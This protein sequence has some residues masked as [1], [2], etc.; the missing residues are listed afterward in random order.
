MWPLVETCPKPLL[1]IGGKPIIQW[2]IEDLRSAGIRNIIISIGYLGEQISDALGRGHGLG[3]KIDYVHQEEERGVA[4]SILIA[5]E[6]FEDED[7]FLVANADIL[8][9]PKIIRRAIRHYKDLDAEAVVSLTLTNTPQFF[10][11]AVIDE[12]A[13]IRK[14]IEKPKPEE[15]QSRYAIAGIYVFRPSIFEHLRKAKDLPVTIQNLIEKDEKVYGSVWERE[16]VEVSYPWDLVQANQ[17]VL[18]K[19]LKGKGS[20]IAESAD[21][22]QP[23]RIEGSVHISD[24]V[25][26][27]PHTTIRGP[28]YIGPD[29]YIGNNSLIREY[30]SLGAN[31]LVGFGCEIKESII[32]DS[33]KIGRLSFVGDSVVGRNVEI[34][35]G[36]QLVNYPL[37]GTTITSVIS[38]KPEIVP[39]KKYGAVIGDHSILS[40]NVS[41]FPGVKVGTHSI[42]LPGTVLAEDVPSRT[43]AR[44]HQEVAF[45]RLD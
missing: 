8:A 25:V 41:V 16:W 26:I 14:V 7:A 42:V 29:T 22:Q 44:P 10:G 31:V 17:F 30:T 4:E 40:P 20:F 36:V 19:Q 34:G 2:M 38:E 45:R 18:N 23:S 24:G 3:V 28:V 1:S 33:T 5:K 12:R 11:I 13:R 6:E 9:G 15:I 21:I 27:R 43:E 37:A 39:R 35:A 32:Y